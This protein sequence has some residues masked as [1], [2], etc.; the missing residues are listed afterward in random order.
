MQLKMEKKNLHFCKR[1]MVF[2]EEPPAPCN[3]EL[4]AKK[5]S[6]AA[7]RD[8]ELNKFP[9]GKRPDRLEA[10]EAECIGRFPIPRDLPGI[11]LM[12]C[13]SSSFLS[14]LSS[15]PPKKTW[16][17]MKWLF[18]DENV[19]NS[20]TMASFQFSVPFKVWRLF[21]PPGISIKSGSSKSESSSSSSFS[22]LTLVDF[23]TG[24]GSGASSSGS[25]SKSSSKLRVWT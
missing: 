13:K 7:R 21:P 18:L 12:I 2:V 6:C 23:F 4:R 20:S 3:A 5:G 8:G 9:W 25:V 16:M 24:P 15:P 1:S 19:E 11:S 17:K 10:V 22:F 14:F